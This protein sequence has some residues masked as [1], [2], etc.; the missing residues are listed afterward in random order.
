MV[1][2]PPTTV[3]LD[4]PNHSGS[5][6]LKVVK[7]RLYNDNRSLETYAVIDYGSECTIPTAVQQMALPKKAES[8]MLRTVHQ[9][10]V[11]L[12]GNSVT[13]KLSPVCNPS[14]Q[15]SI[16]KPFTAD[17]LG[18]AEYCYPVEALQ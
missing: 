14:K 12:K 18:F 4:R 10:V 16:T 1:S 11:Q 15:F 13:L 3:Y 5:V 8:L 2:T 17:D 9:E 7:V 6:M